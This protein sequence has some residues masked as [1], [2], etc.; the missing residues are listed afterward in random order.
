MKELKTLK[1]F[2]EENQFLNRELIEDMLKAKAVEILKEKKEINTADWVE[3][4]GIE[5]EFADL[6]FGNK[7]VKE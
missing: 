2:F 7:E 4:F 5:K 6:C 1:D 3:F